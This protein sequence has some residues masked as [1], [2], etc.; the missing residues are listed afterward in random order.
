MRKQFVFVYV[1]LLLSFSTV[2]LAL[3][4]AEC[5]CLVQFKSLREPLSFSD[6]YSNTVARRKYAEEYAVFRSLKIVRRVRSVNA[7]LGKM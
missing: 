1:F 7:L 4:I 3:N 2:Q 5:A 6:T